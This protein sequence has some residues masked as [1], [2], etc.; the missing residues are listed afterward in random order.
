MSKEYKPEKRIR[1]DD[2]FD[3]R[4]EKYGI[5]EVITECYD[6]ARVLTDGI[7]YAPPR[8]PLE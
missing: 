8:L 6:G 4:M 1:V 2:L 7:G 5:R 3:V